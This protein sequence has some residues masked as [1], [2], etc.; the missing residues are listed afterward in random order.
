MLCFRILHVVKFALSHFISISI[1]NHIH[2][3]TVAD[4][5]NE[6][7]DQSAKNIKFNI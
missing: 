4:I 6:T 2:L 3:L 7:T 1:W 5:D